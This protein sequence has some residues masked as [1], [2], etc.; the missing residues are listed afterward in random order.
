MTKSKKQIPP[1]K[2]Y[3]ENLNISILLDLSDR[4]SPKKYP[5]KSMEFYLRDVGYI[6]SVAEAFTN[7]VRAKKVRKVNDK[8]QLFFDPAPLNPEINAL[9]KELKISVDQKKCF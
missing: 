1:V 3:S 6:N 9:S 2:D 7:H 5:N 4:I 8:M